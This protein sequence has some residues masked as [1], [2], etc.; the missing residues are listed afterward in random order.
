[1]GLF[2][3]FK[4]GSNPPPASGKEAPNKK[5]AGHAKVVGDKRAQTYDRA[6][7][8]Q[9]LADMRSA[10]A[11]EAL[12]RRFTFSI[13]PSITDQEE[14]DAAFQGVVGVGPDAV[15]AVRAFCAKAEV[16]TWPLK[17]LR[18]LL[19]SPRQGRVGRALN[20]ED[21]EGA[22]NWLVAKECR[23]VA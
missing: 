14:K 11:A 18:V 4:K 23:G 6:E 12:L 8:I 10:D 1:M 20:A 5:V 2:D 15:P 7:S 13:D 16:L 21:A 3:F 19:E 22:E 17:I 9:A